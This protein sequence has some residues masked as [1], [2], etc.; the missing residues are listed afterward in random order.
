M[1]KTLEPYPS[2]ICQEICNT[3]F[4]INALEYYHLTNQLSILDHGRNKVTKGYKIRK[5]ATAKA[6]LP[7]YY[8]TRT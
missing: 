3:R 4:Y 6:V 2:K 5:A 8:G 1:T 7:G